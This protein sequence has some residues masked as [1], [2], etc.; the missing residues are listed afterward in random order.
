MFWSSPFKSRNRLNLFWETSAKGQIN[1]YNLLCV[2]CPAVQASHRPGPGGWLC[3][4][5]VGWPRSAVPAG[6]RNPEAA[7]LNCRANSCPEQPAALS[8]QTV[9]GEDWGELWRE[10][11]IEGWCDAQDSWGDGLGMSGRRAVLLHHT[12]KC[13]PISLLSCF[14]PLFPLFTNVFKIIFILC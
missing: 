2:F 13:Y 11:K 10:E 1:Y 8:N 6:Q 7:F 9:K 12:P 3:R 4:C 14:V 5:P